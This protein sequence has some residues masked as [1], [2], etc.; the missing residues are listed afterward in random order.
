MAQSV[1]VARS[2]T[3]TTEVGEVMATSL[4]TPLCSD[5]YQ[6]FSDHHPYAHRA[7]GCCRARTRAL[8]ADVLPTCA[9]VAVHHVLPTVVGEPLLGLS[10]GPDRRLPTARMTSGKK[11]ISVK[12]FRH[13]HLVTCAN[14]AV[15]ELERCCRCAGCATW[16]QYRVDPFYSDYRTT[17]RNRTR[18]YPRKCTFPT[19]SNCLSISICCSTARRPL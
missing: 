11:Q 19:R 5:L 2:I 13:E 3:P 12:P 17:V 18:S 14:V 7:S 10:V 1:L 4:Y 6:F 15:V 8:H 16:G 9:P